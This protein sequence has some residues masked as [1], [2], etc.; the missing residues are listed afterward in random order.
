MWFL[1]VIIHSPG[2]VREENRLEADR[3]GN[4]VLRDDAPRSLRIPALPQR[5]TSAG[6]A[7]LHPSRVELWCEVTLFFTTGDSFCAY[8]RTNLPAR[9]AGVSA[10]AGPAL[11][12]RRSQ[13]TLITVGGSN[14]VLLI[15]TPRSCRELHH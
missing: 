13:G 11:Q 10:A 2:N 14:P 3:C 5:G 6:Y 7:F 12:L 8:L 1:P 9:S 15:G 4:P